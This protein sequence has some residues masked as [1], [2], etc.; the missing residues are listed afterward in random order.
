MFWSLWIGVLKRPS[1]SE[2][3]AGRAPRASSRD[4]QISRPAVTF[5]TIHLQPTHPHVRDFRHRHRP[6]PC[7]RTGRRGGLPHVQVAAPLRR[8]AHAD[9]V[10]G[11][12]PEKTL[13]AQGTRAL[14]PRL[15]GETRRRRERTPNTPHI[16]RPN[17]TRTHLGRTPLHSTRRD[18]T[19]A[20]KGANV[21]SYDLAHMP[22]PPL[23]SASTL[24][25][26]TPVL[27][28]SF[29][30][31]LLDIP[32][33]RPRFQLAEL[34]SSTRV[35]PATMPSCLRNGEVLRIREIEVFY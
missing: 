12:P 4:R 18:A 6:H 35:H 15:R 21:Q 2:R 9:A 1:R 10:R 27:S 14:K 11:R 8:R 26:F 3:A 25:V 17:F 22:A 20:H 16:T 33:G 34:T 24:V 30:T 28:T 13:H 23:P 29:Y 31:F 5:E 32:S 7:A 19:R